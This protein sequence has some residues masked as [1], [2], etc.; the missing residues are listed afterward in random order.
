MHRFFFL[1]KNNTFRKNEPRT[2]HRKR[3]TSKQ[4]DRKSFF[5]KQNPIVAVVI[6]KRTYR[7]WRFHRP[8][9]TKIKI[10]PPK[11]DPK[12]MAVLTVKDV[13]FVSAIK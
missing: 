7:K 1:G 6:L 4:K 12:A 5:L 2:I 8:R 11:D 9:P 10:I 13:C 3:N